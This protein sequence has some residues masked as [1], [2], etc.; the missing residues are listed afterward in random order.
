[1]SVNI[2]IHQLQN[3][4]VSGKEACFNPARLS[5]LSVIS[6]ENEGFCKDPLKAC[7]FSSDSPQIL[8]DGL[9]EMEEMKVCHCS[10]LLSQLHSLRSIVI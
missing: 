8:E 6:D 1:M 2:E 3:D 7:T 4:T 9:S 10:C 5:F